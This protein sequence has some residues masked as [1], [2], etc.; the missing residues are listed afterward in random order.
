MTRHRSFQADSAPTITGDGRTVR[1]RL[2]RWGAPSTVTDDGGRTWYREQFAR[3][4]LQAPAD[5]D[6]VLAA[7]SGHHKTPVGR[8]V[9]VEDTDDGLYADVRLVATP[10]ADELLPLIDER[11]LSVSA[12]FD[13]F[14][15]PAVHGSTVE[16]TSAV[17][18]GLAFTDL[19]QHTTAAVLGR[20]SH[21]DTTIMPDTPDP[22]T[23]ADQAPP[24][25]AVVEQPTGVEH[26]RSLPA[27]PSPALHLAP[28]AELAPA[29]RFRSFGEFV[30]EAASG[31]IDQTE[32]T[33]YYRALS[34]ATN[35]DITGLTRIQWIDEVIDLIRATQPCVTAFSQRPLPDRGPTVQQPMVTTRPTVAKQ[36]NQL[37]AVSSQKV[38]IA[39]VSWTV[40]T[41]AGGQGMSM[42]TLLRSEPEYL[43]EVMRL[44]A[45]EMALELEEA[46]CAG[47]LAA[48]DDVHTFV[49]LDA[50]GTG[51]LLQDAFVTAAAK[52]LGRTAGLGRLPEV[53]IGNVKMW[54]LLA[55]AKDSTGRPLFPGVSPL[56]PTG[57][58][59]ITTTTGDVRSLRFEVAPS[60]DDTRAKAV[61]GVRDAYRTMIGPMQT[62][63]NDVP[64]TLSHEEAV[65]EFAAHGKVD[66]RGLVLIDNAV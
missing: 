3:G 1:V 23:V 8:I 35:T 4:G 34:T 65:F 51:T 14:D 58:I 30:R 37:D 29:S 6:V 32:R 31:R 20:R 43:N 63:Q 40:E 50:S 19:P 22:I 7:R 18:T 53:A 17:L 11:L 47:V 9:S 21:E 12:E 16:R 26:A 59:D 64:E 27:R 42:Q 52:I 44:Y 39:P 15:G 45:V 13:D 60:M 62:M 38:V 56:N 25:P 2:V 49:E 33:R 5:A 48:A 54:T 66:A 41:F 28:P 61:I 24:A 36:T 57:S 55:N 10:A 46:V